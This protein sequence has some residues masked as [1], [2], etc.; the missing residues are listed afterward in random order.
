MGNLGI[1]KLNAGAATLL[2]RI[3]GV[4]VL[5]LFFWSGMLFFSHEVKPW[6]IVVMLITSV[7][8]F[9]IMLSLIIQSEDR[10]IKRFEKLWTTIEKYRGEWKLFGVTLLKTVLLQVCILLIQYS[11]FRCVNIDFNLG[12]LLLYVPLANIITMLPVSL[13]GIGIREWIIIETFAKIPGV[14]P[15]NCIACTMISYTFVLIHA[16]IGAISYILPKP[17][18]WKILEES[19]K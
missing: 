16:G 10:L 7:M 8:A 13:N 3:F 15:E 5:C 17:A 11:C 2:S 18:S 14:T 9:G 1:G 4:F 19:D 12:Y 6:L